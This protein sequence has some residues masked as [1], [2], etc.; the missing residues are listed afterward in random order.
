MVEHKHTAEALKHDK[1]RR[2]SVRTGLANDT[3]TSKSQ[4]VLID[5]VVSS[6][7]HASPEERADLPRY[8]DE[9]SGEFVHYLNVLYTGVY[10]H[11]GRPLAVVETCFK[12]KEIFER[13]D[14]NFV[15]AISL[16]AASAIRSAKL[17]EDMARSRKHSDA[18]LEISQAVSGE[19]NGEEMIKNILNVA[20]D[21]VDADLV[22]LHHYDPNSKQFS[23]SVDS[24]GDSK[25]EVI[26]LGEDVE[27]FVAQ[28]G[29]FVQLDDFESFLKDPR[30]SDKIIE[31]NDSENDDDEDT[32]DFKNHA[33]L[34][35]NRT[36]I[37]KSVMCAPV[38][39]P[40]GNI[41]AV[42]K[43]VNK[44]NNSVH[45]DNE[46]QIKW[47]EEDSSLLQSIAESAGV[48]LHKAELLSDILN[49]Q[50]MNKS[51]ISV[52]KTMNKH[53]DDVDEQI[54]ELVEITY[55]I[56]SVERVT[57]FLVDDVREELICAVSKDK[58]FEGTRLP[59]GNGIA[60]HVASQGETLVIED[61]ENDSKWCKKVEETSHFRTKNTL[62]M[63][64]RDH[65]HKIVAVIQL[66][67]KSSKF[68]DNDKDILDAFSQ[69]IASALKK[70]L[71]E[72]AFQRGSTKN[73]SEENETMLGL[74]AQYSK[75][76][77]YKKKQRAKRSSVVIGQ[78]GNLSNSPV[79][80][81][82]ASE[83]R[84][85]SSPDVPTFSD[86]P[87]RTGSLRPGDEAMISPVHNKRV[88]SISNVSVDPDC[89]LDSFSSSDR[90][91]LISAMNSWEFDV[92]KYDSKSLMAVAREF[93][94]SYNI[95]SEFEM[96]DDRLEK[97]L[98]AVRKNYRKNSFHNFYHASA[99]MHISFMML[100]KVGAE[101]FLETRDVM[102]CLVGALVHD[103]DHTGY[104][105][106]FE[107]NSLSQL[108]LTYNDRS[109]L[110][111]HHAATTFKILQDPDVNIFHALDP[112]DFRY[113]RKSI[114]EIILKTD[115]VNHFEMVKQMQMLTEKDPSTTGYD[116]DVDSDED[117]LELMTIVVHSADLSNP[118]NPKFDMTRQ[119]CHR[120]CEE[121]SRQA[122]KEK[123]LGLPVSPFM[124][125]L[126]T[127]QDI[128]KLQIGFV[129]YV[130]LPLWKVVGVLFPNAAQQEINCIENVREWEKIVEGVYY[131][132]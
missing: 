107:K 129:N 66:L 93:L 29:E 109:I 71:L 35:K 103:V 8:F 12:E 50:K 128:A 74:F 45:A 51:L 59:I 7:Y 55:D 127:E 62:C 38:I 17:Y 30:L 111:N 119:W 84:K 48:A 99:V 27:G 21:A 47:S 105:N 106:D 67:N 25:E 113:V 23:N 57:L 75:E 37:Q 117:R 6:K 100:S 77:T 18:L 131:D 68:T 101:E 87:R 36:Y 126:N 20:V 122:V 95:P 104:N 94:L 80:T 85:T 65:R 4:Y 49:E 58:D 114:I 10:D 116:F 79:N 39:D 46:D 96:G 14:V 19:E 98:F 33:N 90:S 31:E 97:F 26:H 70:A 15:R 73:G 115:M 53:K 56:I 54:K 83:R 78:R 76:K 123:S 112:A 9:D 44:N 63:P 91:K 124:E 3:L 72:K 125:G 130:I 22:I 42:L 92:L 32:F 118:T 41:L 34:Q 2:V 82:A 81:N 52:M 108:A 11:T 132:G 5:N 60:G 43:A 24:N 102:C 86:T 88:L 110:E 1:L 69:E 89:T 61:A 28:N 16:L 120:V 40:E 121:F 64:I 13:Y